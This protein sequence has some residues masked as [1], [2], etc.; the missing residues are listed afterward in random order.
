MITFEGEAGKTRHTARARHW[1]ADDCAAHE[2]MSFHQG[3]GQ[4]A[5]PLAVRSRRF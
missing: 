2:A 1:T 3:W 5:D 4:S